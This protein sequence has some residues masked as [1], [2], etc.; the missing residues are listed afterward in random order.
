M[1][2]V[3]GIIIPVFNLA[4]RTA[5]CLESL[6][7]H[8]PGRF[9]G[10][11]VVDDGSSDATPELIPGLGRSL[12]GP[13]FRYI[14][15]PRNA[16]FAGAC[17]AGAAENGAEYLLF[18]NN[19]TLLTPNWLPPLLTAFRQFPKLGACS[20]LLFFPETGRLQ[21]GGIVLDQDLRVQHLYFLFPGGH[22][23][24]TVRRRF[25]AISGSALMLPRR[26][27]ASLGGFFPGYV[28]GSEDLDLCASIRAL[29]LELT[30]AP[31]SRILHCTSQSPSRFDRV[32]ANTKLLNDRQAGRFVADLADQARRDG[33]VTRLNAWL[34]PYL[35]V[36][37]EREA[38]LARECPAD[39][40]AAAE[41]FLDAQPLWQGGYVLAAR[42]WEAAGAIPQA[43]ATAR[44]RA[45]FF[46]S[47][48][49]LA[50]VARLS[51]LAGDQTAWQESLAGLELARR[52]LDRPAVLTARA[53]ANATLC[54]QAG[55]PELAGC[56]EA[57]IAAQTP[58]RIMP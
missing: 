42:A 10:V 15:L 53:R 32:A 40:S 14:R 2:E 11:T 35:S 36:P 19:D 46:P 41:A 38:A 7:R 16:G 28:N 50:E 12:F 33:F 39:D 18:L 52:E 45:H 29:G 54:R 4:A 51:G 1:A 17:N 56:Y 8:T 25:Q 21:H 5:A 37:A 34:R 49:S 48:D 27:F 31:R 23:A 30:C 57:W 20:P 47:Q 44:L 3:L 13:S 58:Q 6:R 24:L 22:P 43:L 55:R 9:Y 26:L